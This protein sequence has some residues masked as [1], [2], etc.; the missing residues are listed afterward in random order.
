MKT[1]Y[2]ILGFGLHAVRRLMPGFAH[3]QHSVLGGLW[4]RD[5]QQAAA[6]A[7][8]YHATSYATPEDLC[9]SPD[10]DA[11][12]VASPD[13][14]HLEHTLLAL[15]HG[16]PVLCEKPLAM[17]AAQARQMVDAAQAAGLLLGIG[18]NYRFNRSLELIRDWI[19]AGRIGAPMLAHA[20]FSYPAQKSSR[21]WIT[22][23][24]LA[25]GGPIGDVGVHCIDAIRL[26]TGSDVLSV[27]TLAR[28]DALSGGVEAFAAL[29]LE[30]T[31]GLFA[32][33]TT[34]ARTPYRTLIEITGDN[35]VITSENGLS[36]DH[37]V[38]VVLRRN[39]EVIESAALNNLDS[40]TRMLDGFALALRG[41]AT[42]PATAIDSW[43]NMLALDAA[44]KSWRSGQREPV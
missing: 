37:P 42:Y 35:G 1:R 11:I 18:H 41:Q 36:V 10:I 6:N 16:K 13:A 43:K 4:R 27:S 14:L 38:D 24:S 21:K 9:A 15:R 30:M 12:F 26:V 34:S 2:G 39:G 17:N 3:T 33:V 20:Q 28:A 19:A 32:N 22:D 40:Y 5:Q 44:Y 25:N 7:A 23:P 8:A 29:Q 31:G